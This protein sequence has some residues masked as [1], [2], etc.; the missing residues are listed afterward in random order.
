VVCKGNRNRSACECSVEESDSRWDAL[1][2]IREEL[3]KK[4]EN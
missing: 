4:K 1:R 2:G 3:A